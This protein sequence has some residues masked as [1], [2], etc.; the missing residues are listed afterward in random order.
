MNCRLPELKDKDILKSYVQEHYPNHENS[1][2]ASMGLSS[3]DYAA[4]MLDHALTV[5]REKGM[6][7]VILGCDKNN[8]ASASTIKKCGGILFAENENHDQGTVSQYYVIHL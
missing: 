6:K 3:S 8:T 4:E 2:S 5:C 7:K 1:I